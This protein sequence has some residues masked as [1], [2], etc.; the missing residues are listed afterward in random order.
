[1]NEWSD[2]VGMAQL[3]LKVG[4]KNIT[5]SC[6]VFE[7]ISHGII[8]GNK[9]LKRREAVLDYEKLTVSMKANDKT[10]ISVP[11]SI[12]DVCKQFNW[13]K[14]MYAETMRNEVIPPGA[15]VV[16]TA[17]ALSSSDGKTPD[18]D[19]AI[20]VLVEGNFKL[21]TIGMLVEIYVNT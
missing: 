18:T 3:P 5:L 13:P 16:I 11:V 19:A 20:S 10:R 12:G 21:H 17:K 1:M 8:I 15:T 2:P 9:D 4:N 7:N 6:R 14:D